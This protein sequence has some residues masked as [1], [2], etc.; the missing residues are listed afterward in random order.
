M[1]LPLCTSAR[2]RNASLLRAMRQRGVGSLR[3]VV[4]TARF[5]AVVPRLS[6]TRTHLQH[7][8]YSATIA[9]S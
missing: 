9:P 4:S 5:L 1:A 6:S 8:R 2:T 3:V 7:Q